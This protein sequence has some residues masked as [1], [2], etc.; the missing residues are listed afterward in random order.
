M[1]RM[2]RLVALV[3][4]LA[5]LPGCGVVDI[6]LESI[7]D[8]LRNVNPETNSAKLIPFDSEQGMV[9]YFSDQVDSRNDSL[10]GSR[11][12]LLAVDEVSSE[13]VP[14]GSADASPPP[15]AS[16]GGDDGATST[17]TDFS[18]TTIQVE[19]VDEPDVVKT[20]GT[21]LFIIDN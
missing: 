11:G 19:G 5:I 18:Q 12:E 17:D 21:H 7:L 1:H 2:Y 6:I 20:D 14:G 9:D 13:G 4:A 16:L 3:V 8:E 15:A 10:F